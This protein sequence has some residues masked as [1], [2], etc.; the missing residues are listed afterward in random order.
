MF[1]PQD[2]EEECSDNSSTTVD[3]DAEFTANEEDG[4]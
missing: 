3:E 4:K 1:L 2:Y